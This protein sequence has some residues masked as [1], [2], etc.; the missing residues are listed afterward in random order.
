MGHTIGGAARARNATTGLGG[1]PRATAFTRL[2]ALAC[3]ALLG[4]ACSTTPTPPPPIEYLGYHVGPPDQLAITILPDPPIVE[5]PTVRPDGMITVQLI[6]DVQAGGRTTTEIASDI[7]NRIGRY[8][9]GA[10]V[11][12]ALASAQSSLV[13]VL[14]EVKN[15][16]S[17]PLT[18]QM[19]VSEAIGT[20]GDVTLFANSDDIVVVRSLPSTEVIDVDIDAIRSGDLSTNVQLYG[21]DIVYVPPTVLAQIGYAINMV[22]F[23]FQ[24]FLRI[25]TSAA[26]AAIVQ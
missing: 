14:G 12:V 8:K 1:A 9:R 17:F 4:A 13:T 22:L 7:E 5:T 11:T 3:A 24:P 15:P 20:V 26:G 19:R 23:P 21:G 25:G 10:V 6:G 16:S 2:G 18:R